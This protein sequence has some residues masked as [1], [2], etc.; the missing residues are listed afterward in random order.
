MISHLVLMKPRPDL[1][2]IDRNGFA[3]SFERAVTNIASVRNVRVGRRILHGA[4][5]ESG[6]DFSAEYLAVIDF[7]DLDG[8]RAYLQ[9][10]A[11]AE[12]GARFATSLAGAM[13]LDY[14]T[15]GLDLIEQWLTPD[16]SS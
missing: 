2:E 14:E 10:P 11:H 4:G 13:V 16:Q 5:Y 7:D 1:S 8:L 6:N 9:H 3:A 15:G 12:L